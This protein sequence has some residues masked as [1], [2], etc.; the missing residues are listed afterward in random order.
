MDAYNTISLSAPVAVE[1]PQLP[2]NY[3]DGGNG[4]SQSACTIA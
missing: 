3:E 4:N 1:Q 2:T